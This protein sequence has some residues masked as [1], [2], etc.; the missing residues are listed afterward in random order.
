MPEA[1]EHR[2]AS[3]GAASMETHRSVI[4]GR[5]IWRENLFSGDARVKPGDATNRSGRIPSVIQPSEGS[6]KAKFIA[7]TLRGGL[8]SLL[9]ADEEAGIVALALRRS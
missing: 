1:Q 6:H 2:H 5:S 8:A 3:D 4:L 7:G 9:V